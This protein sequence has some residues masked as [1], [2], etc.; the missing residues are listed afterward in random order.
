MSLGVPAADEA[1]L[2]EIGARDGISARRRRARHLDRDAAARRPRASAGRHSSSALDDP[3]RADA[4]RQA[5]WRLFGHT[6]R[7][8]ICACETEYGPDNGFHQPQQLADIAGYYL[9]F[10]L[11][12]LAAG[13]VRADHIA[14]ECEFMDFLSRKEARLLDRTGADADVGRRW[15]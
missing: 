15:R 8:L 6:T 9:A 4:S 14:C 3:G 13:D 7:G 5:Y 1:R 11:R 12:P 2:R 10:G